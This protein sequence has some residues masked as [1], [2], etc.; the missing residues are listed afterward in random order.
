MSYLS[1]TLVDLVLTASRLCQQSNF[2]ICSTFGFDD[3]TSHKGYIPWS[4]IMAHADNFE[5]SLFPRQNNIPQNVLDLHN[6]SLFPEIRINTQRAIMSLYIELS[7]SIVNFIHSNPT[8]AYL[9]SICKYYGFNR[10]NTGTHNGY[11]MSNFLAMMVNRSILTKHEKIGSKCFFSIN[12]SHE[13]ASVQIFNVNKKYA[14]KNESKF[15]QLLEQSRIAFSPQIKFNDCRDIKPL[16][17]DFYL[18]DHECLIEI[19]GEQHYRPVELFG[20][21]PSFVNTLHHDLIKREYALDN[22]YNFIAIP[23]N[24]IDSTTIKYIVDNF[25]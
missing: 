13:F 17:Y 18:P 4:I 20:G 12:S 24:Q 25:S 14:S 22:G 11:P 6:S 19:Q 8:G 21:Y 23:H 16:P 9:S 15:A 3:L 5:T 7:N 1:D 10:L 2:Q